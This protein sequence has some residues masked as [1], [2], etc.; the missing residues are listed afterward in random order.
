MRLIDRLIE[1]DDLHV[2]VEAD[3]PTQGRFVRQG[4]MPTWVGIEHM[5]QA[6]AAWSGARSLRRGHA[7]KLG[8]LLG[9]RKFEISRPFLPSGATLRI[10]ARCEML[11]ING[12][13]AFACHMMLGDSEVAT[14]LVSVYEPSDVANFLKVSAS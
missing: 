14:A 10:H 11:A 4:S 6:I 13:G 7:P 9:S 2:L 12:L 1:A 8:L 5:A 3:V